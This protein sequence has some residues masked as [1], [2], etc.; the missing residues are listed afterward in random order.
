M[1]MHIFLILASFIAYLTGVQCG[2]ADERQHG[3]CNAAYTHTLDQVPS[4]R[5]ARNI[6]LGAKDA[7]STGNVR[8]LRGHLGQR[9]YLNLFTGI[10][11]YY[12]NEQAFIILSTF[13]ETHTPITF[14]FSSRNFSIC[15]PYGFGPLTFERRGR[16]GS[17]EIFIS[18][19]RSDDRWVIN[20]ITI[21][22]R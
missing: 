18:L 19:S 2:L 3:S 6:L 10:N 21:A 15:N 20:Q 4:E 5:A 8:F 11:G 14:T 22:G 7:L 17:A 1:L 9:I 16:R 13:F 12:S